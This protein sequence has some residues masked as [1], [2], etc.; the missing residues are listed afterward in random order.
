MP[1]QPHICPKDNRLGTMCLAMVMLLCLCVVMQMLGAPVTLLNP[2]DAA[3]NLATSVMEGFS[4]PSSLPQLMLSGE[5]VLV[6]QTQPS[7][8]VPVLASALF[9][10]P[11]F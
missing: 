3:D 4:V 11:V 10:P 5:T 7:V 8:H 2:L 6:S 9:H 1:F